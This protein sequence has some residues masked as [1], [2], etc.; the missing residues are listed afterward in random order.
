MVVQYTILVYASRYCC[1]SSHRHGFIF[2][3]DFLNLPETHQ[4][5]RCQWTKNIL[6]CKWVWQ[7][8][9][10]F[11]FV[12]YDCQINLIKDHT[13]PFKHTFWWPDFIHHPSCCQYAYR[14][15]ILPCLNRQDCQQIISVI[16]IHILRLVN[17]FEHQC[18]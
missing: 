18:L 8:A 4:C 3:L 6:Y 11:S 2:M 1:Q 17:I 13:I 5:L 16:F 9:L 15:L 14:A 10:C 12:L 7:E